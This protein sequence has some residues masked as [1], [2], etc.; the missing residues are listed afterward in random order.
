MILRLH[1]TQPTQPRRRR[2]AS[3]SRALRASRHLPTCVH[4][5]PAADRNELIKAAPA[6]VWAGHAHH[7]LQRG[8]MEL[9][10]LATTRQWRSVCS[11]HVKTGHAT[12]SY[13]L[14]YFR[15]SY[16][17]RQIIGHIL[18]INTVLQSTNQ[19][20]YSSPATQPYI[21]ADCVPTLTSW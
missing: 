7:R 5:A 17:V 1:P 10:L 3:A 9:A 18:V 8:S 13:K 11:R 19:S 20:F 12:H 2:R 16:Q 4:G 6:G 15:A 14:T 21:P